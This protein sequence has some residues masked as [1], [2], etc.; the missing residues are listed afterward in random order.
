MLKSAVLGSI[1]YRLEA[2]F[3]FPPIKAQV[4]NTFLKEHSKTIF[5][6]KSHHN[7]VDI[8]VITNVKYMFCICLMIQKLTKASF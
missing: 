6:F 1:E 2:V 5:D 7:E 3:F 8:C 4:S